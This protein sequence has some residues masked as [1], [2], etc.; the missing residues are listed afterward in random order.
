MGTCNAGWRAKG[1]TVRQGLGSQE[2]ANRFVLARQQQVDG[3]ANLADALTKPLARPV[4]VKHLIGM[5]LVPEDG[6]AASAPRIT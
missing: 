2:E 6:R 1:E 3:K 5:G 4:L